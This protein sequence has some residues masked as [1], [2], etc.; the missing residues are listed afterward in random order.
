MAATVDFAQLGEA[1]RADTQQFIDGY[2]ARY[3]ADGPLLAFC[4]Y[5][6]SQLD[7]TGMLLPQRAVQEQPELTVGDVGG[8]Y[9]YGEQVQGPLSEPTAALFEAYQ[10]HLA[11]VPDE[12]IEPLMERFQRMI[13]QVLRQLNFAQLPKTPDFVFFAVGMDEDYPDWASSIPAPLLRQHF[14]V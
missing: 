11:E 10:E 13:G 3:P 8:W 7:A 4:L 14:D 6:D 12:E 1:L 2:A 5:F 9:T